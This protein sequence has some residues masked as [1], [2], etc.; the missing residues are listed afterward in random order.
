MGPEKIRSNGGF[1]DNVNPLFCQN[2]YMANHGQSSPS[3]AYP[4]SFRDTGGFSG[5]GAKGA[6]VEP[7]HG[8]PPPLEWAKAA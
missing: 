5:K 2:L 6:L 3:V 8:E 7:G 1:K 4:Q